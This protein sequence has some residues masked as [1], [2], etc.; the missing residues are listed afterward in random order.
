MGGSESTPRTLT[1]HKDGE[2]DDVVNVPVTSAVGHFALLTTVF[3][4]KVHN[5]VGIHEWAVE[6]KGRGCTCRY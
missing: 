6:L 2:C 1:V 3:F 5:T 4:C